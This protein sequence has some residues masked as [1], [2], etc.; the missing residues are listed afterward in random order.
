MGRSAWFRAVSLA[1]VCAVAFTADALA[2]AKPAVK[3]GVIFDYT[4]PFA[5]GGSEASALG[6]KYAIDI[7]NERGGV[8]GHKID[9]I[10]V[11]AQS[12]P[13]VAINEAIRLLTQEKVN[14]LMGIFSSAQ[15]VPLSQRVE[16]QKAF[17]WMTVCISSAVFKGKNLQYVFRPQTH[18][19]QF[20]QYSVDMIAHYAPTKLGTDP[21]NLRVA[22]IH[23]DGPYGV[24][25]ATAN[26][27]T[28]KKH[29]M[30]VVLKEGYSATAPDLSSLVTKLKRA[31]PDVI[32]H[33]GYN[34]DITLFLRQARELGLRWKALVGHG[35]G[36][37]QIDKLQ[38]TFGNDVDLLYTVDPAASQLLDPAK[39]APGQAEL[40]TEMLKRYKAEKKVEEVPPHLS[41]GFNTAWVFLNEVLPRAIKQYGGYDPEALRKASL[42][43]DIPDGGT[44]QGYGVKF[45]GPG[46]EMAG[47]NERAFP[48]V[49]QFVGGKTKISWPLMVQ[50][51]EPVMPLPASN[52]YAMK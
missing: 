23:E 48:V 10:F 8:E 41:V 11:D 40:V 6:T 26:E 9:G 25:C 18:S 39:F 16:Q 12:K 29:G 42:D 43:V 20:G 1:L 31:R 30:N 49:M 15:C 38:A 14:L 50:T 4:G 27:E 52:P 33:T 19:D 34:P 28:A 35:A 37:S 44:I 36:H 32:F 5:A 13:D 47:Q 24:G 22:I 21:K 17:L 2:Q 7:V 51:D 3:I 45:F 46:T